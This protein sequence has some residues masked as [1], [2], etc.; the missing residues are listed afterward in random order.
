MLSRDSF[1]V[2]HADAQ[3]Q[4]NQHLRPTSY[5]VC[6]VAAFLPPSKS[7][8]GP[9][10]SSLSRLV[11]IVIVV[12]LAFVVLVVLVVVVVVVVVV[13]FPPSPAG[14][15]PS[16]HLNASSPKRLR[17]NY[18]QLFNFIFCQFKRPFL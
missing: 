7:V 14:S 9:T 4:T 10:L 17:G 3:M 15:C 8:L 6:P 1:E 12:V 5:C 16:Y 18:G 2:H 13:D 11:V